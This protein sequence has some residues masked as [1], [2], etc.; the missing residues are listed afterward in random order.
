MTKPEHDRIRGRRQNPGYSIVSALPGVDRFLAVKGPDVVGRFDPEGGFEVFEELSQS[1]AEPVAHL[2]KRFRDAPDCPR[3]LLGI[4]VPTIASRKWTSSTLVLGEQVMRRFRPHGNHSPS[5]FEVRSRERSVFQGMQVL[6][7]HRNPSMP[8]V[9][10]YCPLLH[11]SGRK[12]KD[13][14]DFDA[15]VDGSVPREH[16]VVEVLNL[17]GEM[18]PGQRRQRWVTDLIRMIREVSIEE[19]RRTYGGLSIAVN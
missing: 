1:L 11:V 16:P 6:L 14:P 18:T 3:T 7:D 17:V 9:P 8:D 12:I 15:F 5:P 4:V 19:H 2:L 10:F 13:L